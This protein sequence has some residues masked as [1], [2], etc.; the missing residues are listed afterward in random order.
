MKKLLVGLSVASN[1]LFVA[2]LAWLLVGGGRDRIVTHVLEL[3]RERLVSLWDS[4]PIE[5]SQVVFLGDSTTQLGRWSEFFPGFNVRN[6][7]V[8]GDTTVDVL[9]R[10]HQVTRGQPAIVFLDIGSNDLGSGSPPTEIETRYAEI[11]D[12][13]AAESPETQV[14]I[15]SALPRTSKYERRVIDLNRRLYRLAEGRGLPYIDLYAAF[16]CDDGSICNEYSND[17]IHLLGPGYVKWVEL[18]RPYI[19]VYK[20]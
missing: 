3:N 5:R 6:L 11:L 1:A 20:N 17:K 14:Y 16:V 10:L 2:A 4:F 9:N 7:G 19:T 8:A 18:L 12:R 13:L 15:Q